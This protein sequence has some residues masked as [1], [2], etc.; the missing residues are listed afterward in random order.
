MQLFGRTKKN[1]IF[2]TKIKE[3]NDEL[4]KQDE[5]LYKIHEAEHEF[6]KSKDFDKIIEF[7]EQLW[8]NGGLLFNGSKWTF[9][10]PDLY[11]KVKRYDDALRI[12]EKIKNPIYQDKK[13]GYI[14][15]IEKLKTRTPT[16]ET[17]GD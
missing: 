4:S 8:S 12:L 10:L 9:R 5:Q 7:W 1:K 2:D 13:M 16:E 17:E 14:D 11:I 15:K 6:D 3:I